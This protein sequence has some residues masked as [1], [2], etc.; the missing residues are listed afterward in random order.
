MKKHV[1]KVFGL[2]ALVL[3]LTSCEKSVVDVPLE[4]NT[5]I[6][7]ISKSVAAGQNGTMMQYF[8]WYTPT[9]G[10]HWDTVKNNATSLKNLGVTALWLPPAYKGAGGGYD[11]GYGVY[12]MYDLGEFNQKGSIETKYG[13]KA[14]YLAAISTLK[15]NGIQTYGD[16]VF[17]HRGGAD[18]KVWVD[19]KKVDWNNRNWELGDKWIEAWVNF[20]FTARNNK[21][22]SFKWRWYHFDGVDWDDAG[23]EKA[24][25]KFKGDGKGWDWEV[26]SEN[27]NYDYLM[28]A[29]L[30][31]D[32]PEV[33]KELKDWAV[34]YVNN[35]GVEGFRIDAVKHIK[36]SYFKEWLDYVRATTGK[37]LFSVGEFWSYDLAKLQNF[38][39]KTQRVMSLFDA[40]LQNNFA[41][42]SKSS[43][44]Y[45]MRNIMNNTLMKNDPTKAVT[46]VDN[47]D[48]Q[49]LQAL[50]NPVDY[51]FKPLAYSFILLREEGYPCVF[52]PDLY[53]A[54]YTDKG[55]DGNNYTINLA[56]VS[57]LDKI[58]QARKLFAYGKQNSYMDHWDVI[59]WTRE[60]NTY[61]GSKSMAVLLSDGPGG[62]KWMY[63]GKSNT[64]YYDYLGNRTDKVT[65][66]ADG[67][68]EFKTNGGSVSV[69]VQQ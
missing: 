12:D 5:E 42:A 18:S 51:W 64:V 38:M 48:T 20:D 69:W 43:G 30:D 3:A 39:S 52:Y 25:F 33:K 9:G 8:H 61:N 32:H 27:G 36:Y 44:N 59:G 23:K 2:L 29:D 37:E 24:I 17:N 16:V 45:D 60:G 54:T 10:N 35:T 65:T 67:W 7:S 13:S 34:W 26:D 22:S 4:K 1:L 11:V 41:S 46:L 31:L 15:T 50:E 56:P 28:Y 68:G 6:N 21:Y 53:G 19:T 58:M 55:K 40:P 14:E 63:T 47:H 57:K 66:N 49:P 62:S